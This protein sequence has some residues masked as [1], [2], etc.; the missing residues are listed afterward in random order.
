MNHFVKIA[1]VLI[2]IPLF[3]PNDGW[4]ESSAASLS[5]QVSSHTGANIRPCGSRT[6]A[7]PCPVTLTNTIWD[8]TVTLTNPSTSTSATGTLYV[9]ITDRGTPQWTALSIQDNTC[10]NTSLSQGESCAF[11]L[12]TATMTESYSA[13]VTITASKIN[14]STILV[15][16]TP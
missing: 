2:I 3:L 6:W 9:T 1:F 15:T 14:D 12:H 11:V 7:L 16:G 8:S 10:A 13:T 4:A 5:V